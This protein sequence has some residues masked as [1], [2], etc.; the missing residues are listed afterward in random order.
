MN[1]KKVTTTAMSS[2]RVAI[3]RVS[4][5]KSR[6]AEAIIFDISTVDSIIS[7]LLHHISESVI[8]LLSFSFVSPSGSELYYSEIRNGFHL[9]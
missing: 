6:T 3:Q 5:C 1:I 8:I 7:R 9:S 4:I 2:D